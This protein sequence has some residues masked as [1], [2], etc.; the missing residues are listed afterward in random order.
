MKPSIRQ[1]IS[2][3][4]ISLRSSIVGLICLL[5][6]G[7]G[8]ATDAKIDPTLM[9]FTPFALIAG[10]GVATW[11]IRTIKN[12]LLN[13]L[14]VEGTLNEKRH[15]EKSTYLEYSYKYD[16]M[17]YQRTFMTSDFGPVRKLN[18]GDKITVVVDPIYPEEGL[19]QSI[20]YL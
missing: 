13:G 3:D 5:V 1:I 18:E 9:S 10:V 8:I 15:R 19:I 20:F 7:A 4:D 11:R 14:E 2:Q 16:G 12:V 17:H 6:C